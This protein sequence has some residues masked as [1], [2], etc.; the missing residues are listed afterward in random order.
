MNYFVVHERQL[1]PSQ[2]LAADRRAGGIGEPDQSQSAV[3]RDRGRYWHA[4]RSSQIVQRAA[5]DFFVAAVTY[6]VRAFLLF[7]LAAQQPGAVEPRHISLGLVA[8]C[9][10]GTP[11]P[12]GCR[13]RTSMRLPSWWSWRLMM[14]LMAARF[15]WNVRRLAGVLPLAG[16][17]AVLLLL[18]KHS[19][20]RQDIAHVHMGPMV[21]MAAAI[22]MPFG[23]LARWAGRA[24]CGE[25]A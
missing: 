7:Y 6:I 2:R 16:L 25:C 19:F 11:M 21:A 17:A 10:W 15:E 3:L 5:L 12:S 1:R 8:G 18:Y 20:M 9:G 23:A 22:S 4:R 24:S 14:G 13:G